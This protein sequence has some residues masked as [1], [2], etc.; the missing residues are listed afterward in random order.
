MHVLKIG[1]ADV[2]VLT[3]LSNPE[4]DVNELQ[5]V[6]PKIIRRV[7]FRSGQKGKDFS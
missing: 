5:K 6:Q 4:K 7:I 1:C 3:V 2:N